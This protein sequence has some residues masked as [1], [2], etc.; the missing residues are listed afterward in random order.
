M[1]GKLPLEAGRIVL[2]AIFLAL[3]VV[4]ASA[5]IS[6]VQ[7]TDP[8]IFDDTWPE[9]SRREDRTAFVS[10]ITKSMSESM[11]EPTIVLLP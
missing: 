10:F 2:G 3:L 11:P 4:P 6:F 7:V 1:K 8:H 5:Q 9:D